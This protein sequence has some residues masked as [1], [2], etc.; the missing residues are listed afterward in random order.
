MATYPTSQP[1]THNVTTL[2]ILIVDE[3]RDAADSLAELLRLHKYNARVAYNP[4]TA[5][6][7]DPSDVV[8]VEAR[9]LDLG[10]WE[11]VQQ[12]RDRETGKQPFYIAV[13]T[14]GSNEDR[15]RSQ[16]AGVHL[17]LVKPADPAV[18]IGALKRFA[19]AIG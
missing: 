15:R 4:R 6:A 14:C 7:E 2:S 12:M 10:E 17:H 11:L 16:E 5:L 3:N 9:F 8:I 13:T 18:L 19:R 1:P